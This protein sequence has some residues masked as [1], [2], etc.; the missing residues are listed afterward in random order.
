MFKAVKAALP[1]ASRVE[2]RRR[3]I[4]S[5]PDSTQGK[6]DHGAGHLL[7]DRGYPDTIGRLSAMKKI[8]LLFACIACVLSCNDLLRAGESNEELVVVGEKRLDIQA[9]RLREIY[10]AIR[11]NVETTLGWKLRTP[12]TVF[13]VADRELFEKMSGS[14]LISALAIPSQ[15]SIVI[16]IS[17][18][19][20]EPYLLHETFEHE[21]CHL[22]LHDHIKDKLLPKWLDEGI[23][24]WLSGS[25]G[26]IMVGNAAVAGQIN[27]SRRPIPLQQLTVSFPR[28]RDLLTQA[29]VESRLF[30]EYL[31][32]EFGREPL[33]NVLQYLKDGLPIDQAV[34]KAFP[35]SLAN[36]EE[37]WLEELGSRSRWL[38]WVSQHLYEVLF[39]LGAL[40]TVLAFVRLMVRMKR[41]D[42]DEED[43]E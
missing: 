15:H 5:L 13:L 11:E 22:V 30:V 10:P 3:I 42:P 37:E 12:P 35:K 29:Y 17:F 25:L 6:P 4:E 7:T 32:T 33:F 24:Q 38:L 21:L 41:Y 9:G 8:L 43:D 28:D 40:L 14:P 19:A 36:L 2:I 39:F 31:V 23:C 16:Y 26:E 34:S 1:I 27:P 18:G 20:P